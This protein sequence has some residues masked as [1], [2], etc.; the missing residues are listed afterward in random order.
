MDTR[1]NEINRAYYWRNREA[2]KAR[3]K[4]RSEDPE[5]KAANV[6][7]SRR[8]E[9]RNAEKVKAQKKARYARDRGY[10]ERQGC[11]VCG[12]WAE[13]HHDDYS[14]PLEVRWFCRQHHMDAH[15]G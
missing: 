11:E 5:V 10:I 3:V 4:A 6:Q 13:M 7:A 14:K 1:K 8:W 15:R 2:V 9:A 12:G